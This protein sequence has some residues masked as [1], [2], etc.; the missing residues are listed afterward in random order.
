MGQEEHNTTTR[1]TTS[2][3]HHV[4]HM[5][6]CSFPLPKT[7][8]LQAVQ[9][10]EK[11][12]CLARFARFTRG[13]GHSATAT[14]CGGDQV[15]QVHQAH[16]QRSICSGNRAAAMMPDREWSHGLHVITIKIT[17]VMRDSHGAPPPTL[18]FLRCSHSRMMSSASVQHLCFPT[19]KR[20]VSS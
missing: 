17:H 18:L 3:E 2:T 10:S 20:L 8:Q 19:R 4:N 9:Q 14:V 13:T 16:L 1:A 12:D 11:S 15:D 5:T 6:T 7:S